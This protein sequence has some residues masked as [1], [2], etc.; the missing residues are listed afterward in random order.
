MLFDVQLDGG[1]LYYLMAIGVGVKSCEFLSTTS[2]SL[3]IVVG[4][5]RTL[6]HWI[7]GTAMTGVSG[8]PPRFF[9]VFF[10]SWC[11]LMLG[12]SEAGELWEFCEF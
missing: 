12:E 3:G 4:A 7:Q 8:C 11:S 10:F 2:A 9:W 6:F 1:Y 5:E